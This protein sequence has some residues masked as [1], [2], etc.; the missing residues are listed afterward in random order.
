M[1]GC[2]D[3]TVFDGQNGQNGQFPL[4]HVKMARI[5]YQLPMT[6]LLRLGETARLARLARSWRR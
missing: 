3:L 2:P 6:N 5:S 1:D 4:P